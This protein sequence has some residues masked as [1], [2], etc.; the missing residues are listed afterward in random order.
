MPANDS[1]TPPI[2]GAPAGDRLDVAEVLSRYTYGWDTKDYAL[3]RSCFTADA[4][5]TY[6]SLP[7]FPGGFAAF[8]ELE[9]ATREQ[10]ASTQHF[11]GNLLV[12]VD[13]DTAHCTS[14]VQATHYVQE[15]HAWTT[16]GRYDDALVRTETGWKIAKR[17]FSRQWI[18]ETGDRARKFLSN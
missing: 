6:S 1:S 7:P 12:T 9:R 13:G 5:I 18:N 11:I 14:Y 17:N 16:G 15:G 10:M 8:F 4:E 2:L 3:V